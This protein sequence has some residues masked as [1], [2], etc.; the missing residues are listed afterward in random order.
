MKLDNEIQSPGNHSSDGTVVEPEFLRDVNWKNDYPKTNANYKCVGMA[1][2]KEIVNF[3]CEDPTF[4]SNGQ[5]GT[6]PGL[7]Y[8]CEA[9]TIY[10][11]GKTT[12]CHFPFKYDGEMHT[13]CAH[14]IIDDFNPFGEPWCASE[15]DDEGVAIADKMIVCQDEGHIIY[16]LDQPGLFCPIPFLY[17]KVYFDYCTRKSF[18]NPITLADVYWCPSPTNVGANNAYTQGQPYGMCTEYL[19]PPGNK[20]PLMFIALL[21]SM[22]KSLSR[23]WVSRD[24]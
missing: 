10:D 19:H 4:F 13:S 8:I 23:Q 7:G 16:D 24:L 9:R 3:P 11:K 18:D 12:T 1:N 14:T 22:A 15:V 20:I 5:D 6:K 17:D 2:H 21:L